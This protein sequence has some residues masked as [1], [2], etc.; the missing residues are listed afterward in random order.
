MIENKLPCRAP[1]TPAPTR[2]GIARFDQALTKVRSGFASMPPNAL[3]D[4]IAEAV[5][6]VRAG[7]PRSDPVSAPSA[8]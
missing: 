7:L 2:P 1:A 4:L 5:G 6:A 8:P 3:E